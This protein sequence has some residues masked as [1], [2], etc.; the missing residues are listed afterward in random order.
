LFGPKWWEG[1][2]IVV[3]Q[4]RGKLW[5]VRLVKTEHGYVGKEFLIA[6]LSMLTT[7]VAISPKGDLYVSCHSGLPDWGTGPNGEGKIFRIRYTLPEVPQPVYA[8]SSAPDEISVAFDRRLPPGLTN[9]TMV[10]E[11]GSS[12]TPGDE[13]EVLKPP[14]RVVMEQEAHPRT[15]LTTQGV[16][17]GD[18]ASVMVI[19]VEPLSA[20]SPY[21]LTIG[22]PPD[23]ARRYSIESIF[24]GFELSGVWVTG[25][26]DEHRLKL[27][28]GKSVVVPLRGRRVWNSGLTERGFQTIP[29]VAILS[30]DAPVA[31]A[32]S[33]GSDYLTSLHEKVFSSPHYQLTFSALYLSDTGRTN[34]HL[35][36]DERLFESPTD[37]ALSYRMPENWMVV[38]PSA[39]AKKAHEFSVARNWTQGPIHA[40]VSGKVGEELR[41]ANPLAFF[42]PWANVDNTNELTSLL[43]AVQVIG[44][45]ESGRELF[46]GENLQCATCHRIRGEG[47]GH[48]PDL[49]NLVSRNAAS[50]LVDI[51]QPGATINPDYVAYNVRLR[52]GDEH[53][54]FVRHEGRDRLKI[55]SATG[56]DILVSPTDVAEM[57]PSGVS[58]MPEGLLDSLNESQVNDLLTFL[59]HEPPRRDKAER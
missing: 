20:Q 10:V 48:G 17:L 52:T 35:I 21:S 49:S 18:D 43:K 39:G 47:A 3:G 36:S 5:R 30:L 54:G 40:A 28:G 19:S 25:A 8:W 57:R 41:P 31:K 55:T 27:P 37:G 1:D 33:R 42:L 34:L 14:Y 2:A 46:F 53:S 50:L 45:Y 15:R 32:F 51:T 7:D 24:L 22:L 26:V 13:L 12:V 11:G 44:D 23:L 56:V 6:R 29:P 59:L 4:S 9:A 58:L 38:I 16:R